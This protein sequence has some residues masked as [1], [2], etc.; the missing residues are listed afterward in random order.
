[1]SNALSLIIIVA[2]A[3]MVNILFYKKIV[4]NRITKHEKACGYH[5]DALDHLVGKYV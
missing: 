2:V 4:R 5:L 1:M 3:Y